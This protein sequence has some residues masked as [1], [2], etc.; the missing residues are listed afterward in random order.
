MVVNQLN[1][2]LLITIAYGLYTHMMIVKTELIVII[3]IVMI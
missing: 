1:Q 3:I 2:L